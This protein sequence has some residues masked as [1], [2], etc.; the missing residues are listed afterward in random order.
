MVEC[1]LVELNYVPLTQQHLRFPFRALSRRYSEG[2]GLVM[3]VVHQVLR[4]D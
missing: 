1:S 4:Q 3:A 2:F